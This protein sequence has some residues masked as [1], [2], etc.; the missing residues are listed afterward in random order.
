MVLLRRQRC[1]HVQP[2]ALFVLAPE[3]LLPPGCSLDPWRDY[4]AGELVGPM[5]RLGIL[6]GRLNASARSLFN[7][8]HNHIQ[9]DVAED[10]RDKPV[11]DAV[12][13]RHDGDGQEGRDRIA[14]VLPVDFRR[15]FGHQGA[16][17]DQGA[18]CG[19]GRDGGEDGSKEDGDE[20]ADAC[21]AGCE[22]C[23]AAF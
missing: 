16:D 8:P 11:G 12:G 2:G 21:H 15:G 10:A 22:A 6:V 23:L 18:P 13:E 7:H 20:E 3:I 4:A 1:I 9:R 19:P 17:N 5:I 14:V